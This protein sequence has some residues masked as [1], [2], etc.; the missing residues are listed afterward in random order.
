MTLT[1]CDT[2]DNCPPPAFQAAFN[3]ANAGQFGRGLAAAL[4]HPALAGSGGLGVAFEFPE[5]LTAELLDVYLRPVTATDERLALVDRYVAGMDRAQTVGIYE[6]LKTL[7]APTL[8]VWADSDVFFPVNWAHWLGETI[9]GTRKV[10][11]LPGARLFFP[12][13][14]YDELC[15]LLREHWLIAES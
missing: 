3:A 4:A 1:N 12:E 9:P 10:E 15:A 6:Q 11:V 8:V 13:E 2:D 5:R 14:R 7:Q